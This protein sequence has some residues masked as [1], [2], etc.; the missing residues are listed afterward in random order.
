M[1]TIEGPGA[2]SVRI[3]EAMTGDR[4]FVHLKE[5]GLMQ[6]WELV[7]DVQRAYQTRGI[8]ADAISG[9]CAFYQSRGRPETG[10]QNRIH[11]LAG[12]D[13]HWCRYPP[14]LCSLVDTTFAVHFVLW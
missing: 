1:P 13:R 11:K 12:G 10:S 14:A 5:D 7:S 3:Q 6:P 8:P 2:H 9:I 4:L